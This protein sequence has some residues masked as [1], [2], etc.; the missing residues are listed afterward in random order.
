MAPMSRLICTICPVL[1]CP[2]NEW[3]NR[4]L[5]FSVEG[6]R[7]LERKLTMGLFSRYIS[8]GVRSAE[9]LDKSITGRYSS[10]RNTDMVLNSKKI[11][12]S[13]MIDGKQ[14]WITADTEQEYAEKLLGMT[15]TKPKRA[16]TF[17]SRTMRKTGS[18]YFAN[19]TSQ[20]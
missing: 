2:T 12:R 14:K 19:Q 10:E 8:R 11:R 15:A 7:F 5:Q 16:K 20:L 9:K 17:L 6:G 1:L 4:L 13:V 18:Q 3:S